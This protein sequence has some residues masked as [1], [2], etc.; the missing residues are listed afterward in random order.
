MQMLF[1]P[2]I[3]VALLVCSIKVAF[4]NSDISLKY[5]L[6]LLLLPSAT[7]LLSLTND[8][9]NLF[10]AEFAVLEIYPATLL[11]N[12]RGLWF[13]VHTFYSYILIASSSIIVLYKLKL[14]ER[15][16]RFQLNM[17]LVGI[18]LSV[19][20]NFIM[21][22]FVRIGPVDNT[23]WGLTFSLFFFY[24]SLDTNPISHYILARNQV[25][26]S[27]GD[28]IFVVDIK[29]HINDMNI[30]AKKWLLACGIDS[31]PSTFNELLEQ[32]KNVGATI[33]ADENTELRELSFPT[34]YEFRFRSFAIKEQNIY[35][36]KN[37]VIGAIMTFSDMTAIREKLNNLQEISNKDILT[38][39][40]NRRAFEKALDDFER[41]NV[42]PLCII[43]GDVNG[44][45]AINDT[46]GHHEGDQVI[47]ISATILSNCTA[48]AGI[49]ARVGGDEFVI[50]IPNYNKN[51]AEELISNIKETFTNNADELYGANIALG[52]AIKFDSNEKFTDIMADADKQMYKNKDNDRR[53]QR[54]KF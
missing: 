50:L 41:N 22:F 44:L 14:T 40:H 42:L 36:K 46:L 17:M 28:Y 31:N 30:P 10:R 52:Y 53:R 7:V 13:W 37:I 43:V 26:E 12:E 8:F 33:E 18:I 3:P 16:Y 1:I 9:H 5:L 27:I 45:K 29:G 51:A 49:V 11:L 6:L 4:P 47:K 19:S 38:G 35:N 39:I 21:L 48:G 15:P 23:L 34:E 20:T 25:F 2:Y 32:L 24:F 54:S